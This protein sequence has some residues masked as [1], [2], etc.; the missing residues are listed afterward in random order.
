M[1]DGG[2]VNKAPYAELLFESA[3]VRCDVLC[4]HVYPRRGLKGGS[5]VELLSQQSQRENSK[6]S[7][8]NSIKV[9]RDFRRLL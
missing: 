3:A 2:H 7:A 5:E 6:K 9:A 1:F 4:N 8:Q